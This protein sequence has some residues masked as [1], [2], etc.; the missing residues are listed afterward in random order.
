[1]M[2]SLAAPVHIRGACL[3]CSCGKM[4]MASPVVA[5]ERGISMSRF[6]GAGLWQMLLFTQVN[7]V[8]LSEPTPLA[9]GT[10]WPCRH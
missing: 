3:R 10:K 7:L 6:K 4:A 9:K 8:C 5:L 2:P 1:M